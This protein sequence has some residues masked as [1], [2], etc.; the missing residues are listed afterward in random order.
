MPTIRDD[1]QSAYR[2]EGRP[3]EDRFVSGW[4]EINEVMGSV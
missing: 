4:R 2:E 3:Q 1:V